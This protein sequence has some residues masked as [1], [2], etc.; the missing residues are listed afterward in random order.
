VTGAGAAFAPTAVSDA[1]RLP[2][3]CQVEW[4]PERNEVEEDE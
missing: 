3:S 2:A 1:E 4:A